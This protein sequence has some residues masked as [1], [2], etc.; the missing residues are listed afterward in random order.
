MMKKLITLLFFP[1]FVHANH[2]E[3]AYYEP[4]MSLQT[5]KV[6]NSWV[7]TVSGTVQ[8]T[9]EINLGFELDSTGYLE[10][11]AGYGML[12][13]ETYTEAFV[14]YGRADIVDIYNVGVFAGRMLTDD[15][16]IFG[17]TSYEWRRN[18]IGKIL[19]TGASPHQE[20]KT[21]LGTSYTP[22]DWLNFSYS[23]NHERIMSYTD[24]EPNILH[25]DFTLTFKPKYIEPYV[26]YRYGQH[27]VRPGEPRTTEGSYEFGF[28]FNFK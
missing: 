13:G 5:S 2:H 16:L 6:G 17:S 22:I 3:L 23:L 21:S 27:R 20:W 18:V 15:V 14:S 26:K 28:N 8:A 7:G 19:D 9:E 10:L 4:S 24:L 12:L 11:G 1:F 25:A